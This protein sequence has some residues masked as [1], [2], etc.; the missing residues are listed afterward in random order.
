VI[1]VFEEHLAAV[2]AAIAASVIAMPDFHDD[3]LKAL[4]DYGTD[5]NALT[6]AAGIPDFESAG[7]RLRRA[8]QEWKRHAAG[9]QATQSFT[10]A[11]VSKSYDNRMRRPFKAGPDRE[12]EY[13][14][15]VEESARAL[16]Q[17]WDID[18][19]D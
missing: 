16:R 1:V 14:P 18:D 9:G 17:W 6:K 8:S 13:K 12:F 2:K 5:R 4:A 3:F 7:D 15:T 10:T 19:D 11:L